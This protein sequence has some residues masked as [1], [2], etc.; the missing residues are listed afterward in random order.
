MGHNIANVRGTWQALYADK[1][2]WHGLGV[3]VEG[4][5]TAKQVLKL[6]PVFRERVETAPVYYKVGSRFLEFAEWHYRWSKLMLCIVLVVRAAADDP[7][8]RDEVN[9]PHEPAHNLNN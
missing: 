5:R 6:V 2:A 1:P 8:Q 3:V 4:A 9:P 7:A